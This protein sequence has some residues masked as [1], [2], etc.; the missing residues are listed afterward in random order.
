MGVGGGVEGDEHEGAL[1]LY[2]VPIA[3]QEVDAVLPKLHSM[4]ACSARLNL[5]VRCLLCSQE[6]AAY[7]SGHVVAYQGLR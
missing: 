4:T 6:L 7:M 2:A 1:D 5:A 3:Q